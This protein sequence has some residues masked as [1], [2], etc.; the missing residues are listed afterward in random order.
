MND[1]PRDFRVTLEEFVEYYTNVSASIDDDMYF[2][3]MMNSAWNITGDATSYKKFDK[4]WANEDTGP[5]KGRPQTSGG[6]QR[7][8][9]DTNGQATLKSGMSSSEFPFGSTQKYYNKEAS[10]TRVSLANPK[11]YKDPSRDQYK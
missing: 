2:S 1:N 4:G 5:A 9:N 7:Q 6:Y 8:N 3:T 10:P 11:Q